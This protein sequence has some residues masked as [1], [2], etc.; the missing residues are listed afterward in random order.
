MIE[1][2]E[3][4]R[5]IY[6][7][8]DSLGLKDEKENIVFSFTSGRTSHLSDMEPEELISLLDR[9]SGNINNNDYLNYGKFDKNNKQHTYLLSMC[10]QLGWTVFNKNVQRNVADIVRLGRFIM[11]FGAIK[12]PLIEQ[13][14][15]ELQTTVY[16]FE[17][18]VSKH[19][20]K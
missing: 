3:L 10:M 13:S 11:H 1:T 12:K 16:Q 14:K 9:L 15:Q 19:F 6:G 5:R 4:K 17:Q 7:K 18:M 8:L 20:K 2:N